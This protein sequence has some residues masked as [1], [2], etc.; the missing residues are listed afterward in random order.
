MNYYPY[1]SYIPSTISVSAPNSGGIFSRLFRNGINWS[2]IINNTQKTL[3]I[4]NQTIPMVKQVTPVVK[5]V[6]TIFSVMNEFKKIDNTK[7]TNK[8]IKI[9]D[10]TQIQTTTNTSENNNQKTDGPIF[11]A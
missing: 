8:N 7:D 5:N 10:K 6:K 1:F 3:N 2:G 4:I 11:F 9:N